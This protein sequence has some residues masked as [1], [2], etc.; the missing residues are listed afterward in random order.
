MIACLNLNPAQDKTVEVPGFHVGGHLKGRVLAF[1]PAGKGHNVA[2]GLACLGTPSMALGFV[3]TNEHE[4]FTVDLVEAG[5]ISHY[6]R[7]PGLTRTNTTIIDPLSHTATHVREEGFEVPPDKT[8]E[9]LDA[10]GVRF[11]KY[12]PEFAV[13]SGSLPP[14][15]SGEDFADLLA[16]CKDGGAKVCVDTSGPALA[17]AVEAGVELI[18]PNREELEALLGEAIPLS[19]IGDAAAELCA[20]VPTVLVSLGERGGIAVTR[21]GR[22]GARLDLAPEEVVSTVGCGDAFLCGWLAA[23][24]EGRPPSEAILWAAACGAACVGLPTA[25]GYDRADLARLLPRAV[26]FD[27]AALAD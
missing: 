19:R 21:Q 15:F 4:R 26:A 20:S 6:I 3:G 24:T 25:T 5:A 13:I 16:T 1:I 22:W 8:A 18:K 23:I 9:L 27:P 7:V 17:T 11:A 2:R 10:V 14:G 12:E